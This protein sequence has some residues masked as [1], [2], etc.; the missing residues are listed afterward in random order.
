MKYEHID[1]LESASG[2]GAEARAGRLRELFRQLTIDRPI[3]DVSTVVDSMGDD[4]LMSAFWTHDGITII[5]TCAAKCVFRVE[6]TLSTAIKGAIEA[7]D[8]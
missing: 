6:G 7:L 4:I 8:A 2:D 1:H 5:V 3:E